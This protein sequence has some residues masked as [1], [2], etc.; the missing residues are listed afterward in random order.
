MVRVQC[1]PMCVGLFVSRPPLHSLTR[2]S[3]PKTDV[4]STRKAS[5]PRKLRAHAPRTGRPACLAQLEQ[6]L[7]WSERTH[8]TP[9][10]SSTAP[11]ARTGS[12]RTPRHQRRTLSA[13]AGTCRW[14]PQDMMVWPHFLSL[15]EE[16]H[17]GLFVEGVKSASYAHMQQSPLRK[18]LLV[19]ARYEEHC[20]TPNV[21]FPYFS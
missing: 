5:N 12:A 4:A 1:V 7:R 15:N 3:K 13:S 16:Q 17:P 10:S 8:R 9:H 2:C 20:E 19:A 11:P 18:Y 14:S 21:R 6:A